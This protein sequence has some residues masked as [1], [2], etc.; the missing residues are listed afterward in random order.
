MKYSHHIEF[1]VRD[2]ECDMQ[3]VVNNGVYQNYLEHARHEFLQERGINF[4]E[5]TESGINLVVIRAELD[6]KNSLRSN[7]AFEVRSLVRQISRVRFEFQQ[8]IFKLPDEKLMLAAR[9]TGT[10]LNA[11]G[12]PFVPEMLTQLFTTD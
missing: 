2:Y 6:Y 3:G 12:R 1:K 9:I 4:A 11:N 7:D 8:D 5:V 10:S